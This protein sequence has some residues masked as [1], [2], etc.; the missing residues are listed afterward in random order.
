MSESRAV[1]ERY[2]NTYQIEMGRFYQELR[3][4]KTMT[5]YWS[6]NHSTL[7]FRRAG[8]VVTARSRDIDGVEIGS[9]TFGS[10][11]DFEHDL[12]EAMK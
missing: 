6:H 9:Y 3:R 5:V 4:L 12:L 7:I 8:R 1:Q 11:H 10:E 2:L